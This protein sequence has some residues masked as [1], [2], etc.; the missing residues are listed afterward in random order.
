MKEVY[1]DTEGVGGVYSSTNLEW[2]PY[3]NS[4]SKNTTT[5]S[6]QAETR[7]GCED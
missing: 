1:S 7:G 2:E 3:R 6:A 4:R 5:D